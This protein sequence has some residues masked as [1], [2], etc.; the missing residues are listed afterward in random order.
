M[1][2][3]YE[4]ISKINP[5][6]RQSKFVVEPKIDGLTVVLHYRNGIFV[7]GA[8]RG[9]GSAGEDITS[10]LKTVRALPLKIP[11][12]EKKFTPPAELVVRGEAFIF[13]KDFTALNQRLAEKGDKTYFKSEEYG[14]WLSKAIG[15]KSDRQPSAYI[16]GLSNRKN[17]R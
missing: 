15:S 2:D 8:T 1:R 13:S 7:Q 6:V 10:N 11:V 9:D 16:A 14:G 5:A 3:W 12:H 4:Q 17:G